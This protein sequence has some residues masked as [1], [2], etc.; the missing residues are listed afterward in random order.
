MTGKYIDYHNGVVNKIDIKRMIGFYRFFNRGSDIYYLERAVEDLEN[1]DSLPIPNSYKD[2]MKHIED[3]E[4]TIKSK[5]LLYMYLLSG[6]MI[7]GAMLI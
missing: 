5:N 6:A 3:Y 7:G 1:Y 2:T 4:D